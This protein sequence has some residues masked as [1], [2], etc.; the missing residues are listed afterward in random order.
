MKMKNIGENK[1]I[2]CSIHHD[3]FQSSLAM[4]N[5]YCLWNKI[6]NLGSG[7]GIVDNIYFLD[8][9]RVLNITYQDY[10]VNNQLTN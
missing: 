6:Y 8:D 10:Q 4:I 5:I 2:L 1:C 7:H 3:N 9:D